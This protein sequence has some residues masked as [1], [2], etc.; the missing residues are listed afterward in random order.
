MK[1][2]YTTG[3]NTDRTFVNGENA[4]RALVSGEAEVRYTPE[5]QRLLNMA[6]DMRLHIGVLTGT[7][8]I[9]RK[10]HQEFTD[11]LDAITEGK[12]AEYI[13]SGKGAGFAYGRAILESD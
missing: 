3:E 7:G 1:R 9:D 13:V 12:L 6:K 5:Q 4:N 11:A 2:I 8:F 10:A